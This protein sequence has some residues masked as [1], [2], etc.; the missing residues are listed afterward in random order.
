M[1]EVNETLEQKDDVT[2]QYLTF[3][4]GGE[5]Y[6]VDILKVQ[7][8]RC[9]EKAT[10][11]PH[12][13]D[14]VLGVINLRGIVVPIVDL[15]RRFSLESFD[16]NES[17]VVV[18]IKVKQSKTERTVGMVVDAI[19]DVYR[20]NAAYEKEAPDFGGKMENEFVKGLTTVDEKM[21]IL[22]D[23]DSLAGI[24]AINTNKKS[25]MNSVEVAEGV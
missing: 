14:Y 17:T 4:L 9:W 23:A 25:V 5:E 21:V 13:P 1:T 16:F 20:V 6:G 7:E 24:G 10:A 11:I 19:S 12:T 2:N 18:I 8:I 3:I 15:R 22:L